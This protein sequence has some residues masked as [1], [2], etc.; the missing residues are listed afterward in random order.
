MLRLFHLFKVALFSNLRGLCLSKYVLLL[1]P[2][3]DMYTRKVRRWD[4]LNHSS[5]AEAG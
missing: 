1:L 5:N 2:V 3:V 4:L